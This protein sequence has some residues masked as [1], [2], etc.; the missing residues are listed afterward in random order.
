M[1]KDYKMRYVMRMTPWGRLIWEWDL[2]ETDIRMRL[3]GDYNE[4]ATEFIWVHMRIIW[5]DIWEFVLW[6]WDG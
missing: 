5:D 4:P 1:G 3:V 2:M 6:D